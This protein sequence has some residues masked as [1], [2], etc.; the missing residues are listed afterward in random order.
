[1]RHRR[2][3]QPCPCQA[4][5]SLSIPQTAWSRG[6]FRVPG[7]RGLQLHPLRLPTAPPCS[8]EPSMVTPPCR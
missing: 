6:H 5:G 3:L 2:Q 8:L 1:V 7:F 4:L